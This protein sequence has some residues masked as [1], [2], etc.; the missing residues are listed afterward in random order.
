MSAASMSPLLSKEGD[1][2]LIGLFLARA[3]SIRKVRELEICFK[4]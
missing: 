2:A 3:S 1:R 4:R